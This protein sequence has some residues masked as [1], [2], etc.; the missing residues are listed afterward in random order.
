MKIRL[1]NLSNQK[2]LFLLGITIIYIALVAWLHLLRGPYSGDEDHFWKASL[3]FSHRLLP[4]IDDLRSYGELS[5]PLP[6]II[7]GGLEYL[8]H[9][10]IFA[11]RLL[12]L[13]LSLIIVFI[14]GWPSQNRNGRAILCLIGLFICPSYLSYSGRLYTEQI[15]CFLLLIGFVSYC[16]NRHLLSSF[17]FI[18]AIASRQFLVVFPLAIATYEFIFAITQVKTPRRFSLIAQWRCLAPLIAALSVFGWIYLFQGLSPNIGLSVDSFP[19]VQRTLWALTPGASVNCLAAV[20]LYLVIPEFIL[21]QQPVK[22]QAVK[23]Q[24]RKIVI[25]AICL[26]LYVLVFPPLL[27][28]FGHL[29]RIVNLLPN[30]LLKMTLFYSLALLACIRFCQPDLFSLMVLFNALIMA[31]AYPWDKYVLPLVIVFWYLK[32]IDFKKGLKSVYYSTFLNHEVR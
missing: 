9:Q 30:D 5:T 32:S 14:I 18:L 8:F 10:G 17:A 25:I 26:L 24:W 16:N 29:I 13:T 3:T 28:G 11:G 19:E 12:N 4:S 1:G 6:F 2:F 15:A 21:F 27:Y 20:G 22:L 7:F 23:Q 31:K